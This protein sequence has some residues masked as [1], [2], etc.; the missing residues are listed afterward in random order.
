[1]PYAVSAIVMKLLA[2]TAEDRY[3][4][5]A[6]LKSDLER[7]LAEWEAQGR[8]DDFVL[9]TNR[10][11][12]PPADSRTALRQGARDRGVAHLVRSRHPERHARVDPRV[13]PLRYRQVRFVDEMQKALVPWEGSSPPA[14]SISASAI[15]LTRRSRMRFKALSEASSPRAMPIWH[16]GVT[17]CAT[18]WASS[19]S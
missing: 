7:S 12:G 1:M 8:I 14:S 6:G 16:P 13:R 10:Y 4:T 9:G 5:A 19:V 2:K 3:Q 18:R 11:T 15:C 17:H